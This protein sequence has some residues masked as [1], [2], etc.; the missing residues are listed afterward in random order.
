[1]DIKKYNKT[2]WTDINYKNYNHTQA[3]SGGSISFA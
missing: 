2:F 1:M 3:H